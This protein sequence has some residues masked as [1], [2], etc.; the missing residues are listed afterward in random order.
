VSWIYD[1]AFHTQVVYGLLG[2]AV[3]TFF[4]LTWISAPYGRHGRGGW[5]PEIPSRLGWVVMESPS[6]LVFVAVFWGGDH[7]AEVVPLVFLALWQLHYFH[8]T[9]IFPFRIR[10][11]GKTMPALIA[12]L[13]FVFT[14]VNAWINALW[15]SHLGS[16]ALSWL[17]DPRF[18]VGVGIFLAG[19]AIN[20]HADTV[21]INLRKP[22]ETGY[23]VP[24]G[25]L[26]RYVSCPNY[27]GE[28]LEWIG[29]AVA[30]WSLAG[31]AFAVYTAANLAPRAFTHH[32]WY[33]ETFDDY[34]AERK[35]LI[36]FVR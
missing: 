36:P 28:I 12:L 16:Y 24:K 17:Y 7:R 13:A 19:W 21:L 5:G 22:G 33:R 30:T 14:T 34:P 32:D 10:S 4:A 18:L 35:A 25:G 31:L 11:K 6:V 3:V 9:Y 29:W 15:I 1:A 26:Y 27:F 23:K 2:V 20:V 8:R